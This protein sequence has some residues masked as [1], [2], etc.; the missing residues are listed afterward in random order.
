MN[1]HFIVAA[2]SLLAAGTALA[3]SSVS[4]YGRLNM[5]V[6]QQKNIGAVG[7]QSVM[8]NNASRIGFK[9]V[10]DLGGGL[11][12]EFLIEHRF[13]ADN[14]A[15]TNP[16]VFWAGDSYV[17]LS[18]G[19][20][21]IKLGR[22]TSAAYYATADYISAH[23]HDTGTSEDKLYT[24]LGQNAN[25]VSY[26]TPKLGGLTAEVSVSASEGRGV[27]N[28]VAGLALNYGIGALELGLGYESVA[29]D[30]DN[31][32]A[33]RANYTIGALTLGGY[34]QRSEDKGAGALGKRDA[35]RFAVGYAIGALELHGNY[36]MADDWS[37]LNN[38]DAS[39]YTL[40]LN[41]NL[42]KRTK[43][44]AFY[45]EVDNSRNS[46][47]GQVTDAAGNPILGSGRDPSAIAIGV[48]HNF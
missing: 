22:L 18:G 47:Y 14:G 20:G 6:E 7:T 5:T 36:G 29:G 27:A 23:N 28:K 42:S 13:N 3:Q 2:I 11:K 26:T 41:Y 1:R 30:R 16:S 25:T 45:T 46:F 17:G 44:Y 31:Q 9:G 32:L 35:F 34:Y 39:Q 4:V 43:V 19:F 38:S 8:Q 15:T 33:L 21:S 10:E 24:Y 48:R 37:K 12:A 40:G